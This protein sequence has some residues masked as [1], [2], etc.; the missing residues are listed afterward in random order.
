MI[1]PGHIEGA[2]LFC[3]RVSCLHFRKLQL[4]AQQSFH[5]VVVLQLRVP[6]IVWPSFDL[7]VHNS[8]HHDKYIQV[9]IEQ[10]HEV[11]RINL[12]FLH[13]ILQQ[14]LHIITS[15]KIRNPL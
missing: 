9:P 15:T 14:S 13:D 8:G 1:H 10:K 3:F 7:Q 11:E 2:W 12:T 4:C 5:V 6:Q